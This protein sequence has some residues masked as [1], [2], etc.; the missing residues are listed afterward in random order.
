MIR[1]GRVWKLGDNVGATDLLPARYDKQGMSRQWE[2]CAKHV[3]EDA[4][5][6]MAERI[7][8]GDIIVAG[9]GFGS[10]HAH[11]YS[12]AVMGCKTAGIAAFLVDGIGGLFQRACIDFG[13][14]AWTMKGIAA[15]VSDGDELRADLATGEV[16]NLSTG[17]A[18][19][20]APVAPLI[21][22]ILGAG[23][24]EPWALRRVGALP[25]AA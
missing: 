3:L 19:S 13:M 24:S 2:E 1:T 7:R 21:L 25:V 16:Q 6:G 15:L 22:E 14:P 18:A 9:E 8:P 5:P 17:T 12:A 23:G 10:G 11:Y 20:F 4:R